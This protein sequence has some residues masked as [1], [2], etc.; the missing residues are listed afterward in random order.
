[1]ST[2]T[3]L[4]PV[5]AFRAAYPTLQDAESGLQDFVQELRAVQV[6][7]ARMLRAWV[8]DVRDNGDLVCDTTGFGH[9]YGLGPSEI[10]RLIALGFLLEEHPEVE[11]PFLLGGLSLENAALLH[12]LYAVK[13][14]A[15][16]G[17]DWLRWAV[18]IP[19]AD[20]R[21]KVEKRVMEVAEHGPVDH[22]G[23]WVSRETRRRFDRAR[24]L[25]SRKA[26]RRLT[27][28][29]TFGVL[30]D[31]YL[32]HHDPLFKEGRPSVRTVRPRAGDYVPGSVKDDVRRRFGD[33]CAVECCQ[34]TTF[35]EIAH[36]VARA[37]GGTNSIENLLE[38]CRPHHE[39]FDAKCMFLVGRDSERPWFEDRT[40]RWVG[41]LRTALDPGNTS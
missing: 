37:L 38:I 7:M 12:D 24:D 34:N 21:K 2:S 32:K 27:K 17:E 15:R 29:E 26:G 6:P 9:F 36:I 22:V 33:R 16:P 13:S 5:E 39:R 23:V 11:Q 1:M 19:T 40:G 28:S 41:W 8:E 4:S 25:A 3:A 14:A 31:D 10:H 20:F 35:L 30:V 18:E